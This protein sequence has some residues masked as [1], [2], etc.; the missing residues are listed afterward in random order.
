MLPTTALGLGLTI[1][2][3]VA[4]VGSTTVSVRKYFA[5]K[6]L[7]EEAKAPLAFLW[8]I[9][10][11]VLS[12]NTAIIG[13]YLVEDSKINESY[14]DRFRAD[15]TNISSELLKSDD[16]SYTEG[17][18]SF[19]RM[20]EMLGNIDKV[21]NNNASGKVIWE[22]T[23]VTP[24]GPPGYSSG[25]DQVLAQHAG[26][27]V[28]YLFGFPD[29]QE[30]PNEHAE[31]L[32]FL[33][34]YLTS[35][36]LVSTIDINQRAEFLIFPGNRMFGT[37]LA[38]G[39]EGTIVGVELYQKR[40]FRDMG[41]DLSA[42]VTSASV[43]V[44]QIIEDDIET[45]RQKAIRFLKEQK[46]L[47]VFNR[48]PEMIFEDEHATKSLRAMSLEDLGEKVEKLKIT[49]NQNHPASQFPRG[50]KDADSLYKVI[51]KERK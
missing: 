26:L 39:P 22:R 45:Q 35:P 50:L 2:S 23:I 4:V 7:K 3:A 8:E 29:R 43:A 34:R 36:E 18:T 10:V 41:R 20:K 48:T 13:A 33:F 49:W 19:T 47:S 12:L 15:I 37:W 44:T 11:L 30:Y 40:G 1:A 28:T 51:Q 21:W 9:P 25:Q 31:M 46:N 27:N 42:M 32:A 14:L 5:N 38:S 16:L 6:K 24:I 17:V